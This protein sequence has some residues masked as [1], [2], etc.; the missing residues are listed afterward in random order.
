MSWKTWK[1]TRIKTCRFGSSG[2][3]IS[4]STTLISTLSTSCSTACST[5]AK[6]GWNK[7][8]A[9]QKRARL[10]WQWPMESKQ[11]SNRKNVPTKK[12][13]CWRREGRLTSWK[14]CYTLFDVSLVFRSLQL[15]KGFQAS[16]TTQTNLHLE[17]TCLFIF[18]WISCDFTVFYLTSLDIPALFCPSL[19]KSKLGQICQAWKLK[20]PTQ[21]PRIEEKYGK[22]TTGSES[23]WNPTGFHFSLS[24]LGASR[25][26]WC[27]WHEVT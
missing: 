26:C 9:L 27:E 13:W 25:W 18:I 14:I 8:K 15:F 20:N 24:G 6:V 2:V 16:H 10:E 5:C 4:A 12:K 23:L 19:S 11:L 1:T 22:P 7:K 21:P 17:E 3:S